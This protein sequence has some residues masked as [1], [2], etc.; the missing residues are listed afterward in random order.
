MIRDGQGKPAI[1][2]MPISPCYFEKLYKKVA[3]G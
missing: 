3:P 2:G 1:S